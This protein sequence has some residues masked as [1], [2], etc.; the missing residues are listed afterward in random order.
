M[1]GELIITQ[2]D[3]ESRFQGE[4][5]LIT[6]SPYRVG[7]RVVRCSG[8]RAVIKSEYI[9]NNCCP[10][11][12]CTPFLPA[13]VSPA[14]PGTITSGNIRSL[15]AFL[16]LLILSAAAAY[17]PFAFPGASTFLYE[18]SFG[19][20]LGLLLISVG[21]VSLTAA[22]LLYFNEDARRLWQRSS[23]GALLVLGPVTA[24]YF[25]LAVLWVV[26][27]AIALAVA[28]ACFGLIIGIIIGLSE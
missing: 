17:L 13:P 24:P 12:G 6:Y 23:R 9:T 14:Q 16:W 5:D 21:A 11:C 1:R 8:C 25:V 10:L 28:A 18:A 20:D 19:M 26:A 2:A 4:R 27:L 22:L 3:L 15:T 7:D